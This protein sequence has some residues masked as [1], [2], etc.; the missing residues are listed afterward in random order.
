MNKKHLLIAVLA[1]FALTSCKCNKKCKESENTPEKTQSG[2]SFSAFKAGVDGKENNLYVMKNANGMEVCVI[3]FGARIVSV[4]VPDKTGEMQDVVLGF[5]N[6]NDFL[7][8]KTDFGAAIGRY[9]NRVAK[10]KFNLDGVDY[11]L[12]VNNNGNSLHGGITGFQ[13]QMFDITQVDS[14]TLECKFLSPDG[15]NGFPGNLDVKVIYKLTDDNAIDISYEAETDKPTIVNLTNHSYF[16]LS[17][18]PN[19]LILDHILFMDCDYYNPV[20]ANMIP[21]GEIAKVK[22]TP[23]DFT[24]PTIIGER[25]DDYTFEQLKLGNGYDHNWIFNTPGDINVLGC[26]AVCPL[27]GITLEVYTTEPGVQFY[28]GNFLNGTI[29]GKRGI[30]YNKRA[31]LCLETQHYPDSPNQPN[32]PSTV[33]RP[34]EKYTSRCIYKF[35]V[36]NN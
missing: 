19:N 16:N 9:G 36:N 17:G 23:M 29:T 27:T 35:G 3:N 28:S 21:T 30:V 26:Q 22:N 1:I 5:D 20:N 12:T 10:G 18:N 15:D 6:I 25:I 11:Q 31:A 4:L 7:N 34:G 8:N 24:Q 2:L 14:V 13:Y 33:L 32:F